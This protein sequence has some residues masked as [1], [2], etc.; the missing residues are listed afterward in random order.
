MYVGLLLLAFVCAASA[1]SYSPPG[2][3]LG[4]TYTLQT[5]IE[6][7]NTEARNR[8][9]TRI[10]NDNQLALNYDEEHYEWEN[11]DGWYNNPAHPEWGGAGEYKRMESNLILK[12]ITGYDDSD[13]LRII[14]YLI[15]V[16]FQI[17]P[18][19][20]RPQLCTEMECMKLLMRRQGAM[21]WSSPT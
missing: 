19:K 6:I 7:D 12:I 17:F 14:V 5:K 8:T 10:S 9:R 3:E 2:S 18:W 15:F 1:Q 13:V 11:Y 20:G 16:S 4:P 21:C